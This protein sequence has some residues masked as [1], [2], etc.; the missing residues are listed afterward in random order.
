MKKIT[1]LLFSLLFIGG[2]STI[3]HKNKEIQQFSKSLPE[4]ITI[5]Y[6]GPLTGDATVYGE[7]ERDVIKFAL[8]EI[9]KTKLPNTDIEVIYED[10]GCNGKDAVSA[11]QKLV[12]VDQTKIILG[13]ACSGETLAIAPITEEKNILLFSAFSSSPD[14]RFAGDYVFRN[15]PSDFEMARDI[16]QAI[17]KDGRRKIAI[18]TETTDF[19]KGIE[20]NLLNE[21]ETN[22]IQIVAKEYYNSNDNDFRT[23]LTKIKAANPDALFINP[24]S[25]KP[26]GLI[27][28]QAFEL[29]IKSSLYGG[30]SFS[31]PQALNT[32]GVSVNGLKYIDAPGLSKDNI[33]AQTILSQ[34]IKLYGKP[35]SE[36]LIATRYDSML[37]IADAIKYC[38]EINTDCIRDYLYNLDTYTGMAGTYSFDKY[39]DP[40][41]LKY[42]VKEITD[43][44]NGIIKEL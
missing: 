43:A 40:V 4:K 29:E 3:S 41:G 39:G 30:N 22:G 33:Y 24:Q 34:Y 19:A 31:D 18:I 15:S 44:E 20:N 10:G 21:L 23:Q 27:A 9:K 36:W 38:N 25:G 32:A 17:I 42:V 7:N 6:I 8:E 26:A 5:G 1:L 28:K 16:A 12:N 37:L 11:A 13:G 35:A 2:C 14:I